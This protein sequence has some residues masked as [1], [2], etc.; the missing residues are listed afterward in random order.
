MCCRSGLCPRTIQDLPSQAHSDSSTMQSM[1]FHKFSHLT[2]YFGVTVFTLLIGLH[3]PVAQTETI[4]NGKSDYQLLHVIEV[5]GRQGVAT[6][7]ES[8]FV[9]GNTSLYRYSKSGELLLKNDNALADLPRAANHIDDISVYDGEIYAG[10]EWFEDGQGTDI[11]IAI[12]D[13]LTLHYK[14]SIPWKP[15]SGQVE[16]SGVAI[17]PANNSIWLSDWVNGR[18]LY[19]YDREI[20]ELY[21]Y[22][23]QGH[24]AVGK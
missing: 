14:R 8:Y 5:D 24:A 11:Q 7:G 15:E 12:Y 21:V 19:R 23:I 17:D 20:H 9:S 13:A 22:K 18:Y 3:A 16:V 4:S 6:D 10:I 1:H 2:K